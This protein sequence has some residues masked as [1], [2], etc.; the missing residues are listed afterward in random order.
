MYIK[1]FKEV[2]K[3]NDISLGPNLPAVLIKEENLDTHRDT[4]LCTRRKDPDE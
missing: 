3:L 2:A 4:R 1:D